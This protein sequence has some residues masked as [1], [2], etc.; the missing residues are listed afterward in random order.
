MSPAGSGASEP[1]REGCHKRLATC[2]ILVNALTFVGATAKDWFYGRLEVLLR[3]SLCLVKFTT[4]WYLNCFGRRVI[5][6]RQQISLSP[7]S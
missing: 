5:S 7:L 6:I 1:I 4:T 3:K 2:T